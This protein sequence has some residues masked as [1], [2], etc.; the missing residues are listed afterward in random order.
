MEVDGIIVIKK[1]K[2]WTSSDVVRKVKS[3]LKEK[4]GHIGTLDP[5]ATGVLP[6]LI[7]KGTKISKYLINH[8]KTYEATLKL[9]EKRETGDIEGKIIETKEIN[10]ECYNEQKLIETLKIFKGKQ[11]QIPPIYSAIKVNGKKL[12]EYARNGKEVEIKPR[13]IEIYEIELQEI[14]Q[15]ENEIKYKV[16]CSKGTYIRKLCEDIAEKLGTVGYMKELERTKSGEFNIE[17]A[18]TIE[19]LEKNSK[20]SKYCKKHIITIEE[21]FKRKEKIILGENL[22]KK[23]ING[24]QITKNLKDDIY[25]IYDDK[26][27]YIGIGIINNNKL[28]RDIV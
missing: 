17:E 21:I 25:R 16:S 12:Y 5:N 11:K 20:D 6:I 9:G 7:G 15:E 19:E 13:D 24:T 10:K 18:I 1:E 27:N 22:L 8:D 3:I 26:N 14:N 4:T 28:K 23:F 2:E